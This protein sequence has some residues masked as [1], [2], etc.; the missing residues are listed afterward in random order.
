M[1]T[2]PFPR[3]CWKPAEPS[4]RGFLSMWQLGTWWCYA[5]NIFSQLYVFCHPL[6]QEGGMPAPSCLCR[7]SRSSSWLPSSHLLVWSA[8]GWW[9]PGTV[10]VAGCCVCDLQLDSQVL[11][12]AGE[13]EGAR[14]AWHSPGTQ[15]PAGKV[16]DSS[17]SKDKSPVG[18]KHLTGGARWRCA[19][20]PLWRTWSRILYHPTDAN[21]KKSFWREK[22]L[23]GCCV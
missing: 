3:A 9:V 14:C 20:W 22:F 6:L 16:E 12:G 17:R 1:D 2:F 5:R 21:W 19:A 4:D 15:V 11:H 23:L 7:S 18:V 8:G 13:E 10:R